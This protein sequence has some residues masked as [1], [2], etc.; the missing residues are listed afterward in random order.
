MLKMFALGACALLAAAAA[1]LG[2]EDAFYATGPGV[3][4]DA[5]RAAAETAG[6][7]TFAPHGEPLMLWGAA[8][9]SG[10]EVGVSAGAL[11]NDGDPDIKDMG[12]EVSLYA[13]KR[14]LGLLGL[15][16][17]GFY[18][19]QDVDNPTAGIGEITGWTIAGFAK[20][21]LNVPDTGFDVYGG[22]GVGYR[23]DDSDL[24]L[25][26]QDIDDSEVYLLAAGVRYNLGDQ[27]AAGVEAGYQL[28]EP[29][30]NLV[31]GG[32]DLDLNAVTVRGTFSIR[33]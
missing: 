25:A 32:T 33:F 19:I 17:R 23:I 16:L 29:D 22:A 11:Y 7:A 28:A 5:D 6:T 1:A 15:Q 18:T 26:I 9:G 10:M 30:V 13:E 21:V 27:F 2:S 12:L 31:L 3:G 8:G 20:V 4:W 14:V 24:A